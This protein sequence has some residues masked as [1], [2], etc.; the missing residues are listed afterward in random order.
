M[1]QGGPDLDDN[2]IPLCKE[3]SKV[4]IE[5]GWTLFLHNHELA[6]LYLKRKGWMFDQKGFKNFQ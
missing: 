1:E 4:L 6:A 3:H 5:S 2:L